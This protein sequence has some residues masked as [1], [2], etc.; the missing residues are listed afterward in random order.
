ML[1]C[2]LN[3]PKATTLSCLSV[4]MRVLL[5]PDGMSQR[6]KHLFKHVDIN[7]AHV[8]ILN[9]NADDLVAEYRSKLPLQFHRLLPYRCKAFEDTIVK[10]GGI[11]LFFGGNFSVE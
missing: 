1:A 5:G 8:H 6:W 10:A 2:L 4:S 3:I 11:E 9:G 7:P